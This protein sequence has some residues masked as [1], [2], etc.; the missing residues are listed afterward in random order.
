M[1]RPTLAF[2]V[3]TYALAVPFWVLGGT[4]DLQLL[5][6][7][8]VAGLMFVCPGVAALV[9]SHRRGGMQS[10]KALVRKA[11]DYR[12]V[13]ANLLY[14]PI[15]LL[16]P[17]ILVLSYVAQRA[18]DAPVPAPAIEVSSAL[19]LFALFLVPAA[20]EE[21]GWTGYALR[22]LQVRRH[23]LTAALIVGVAWAAWH[24]VALQQVHRSVEW[25][26]W[27][28]LW[29]VSARVIMVWIYNRSGGS[30]FATV[31]YHTVS[32]AAW[33]SYPV[34]GSFFDPRVTGLITTVVALAAGISLLAMEP[35]RTH[36][37]D[38]VS[39]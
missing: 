6:G 17:G 11:F 37:D 16:T 7:L 12:S 24:W 8:P 27:W 14:L 38:R 2:F 39:Q 33:Q 23:A 28:T 19:G 22:Q 20:F 18:L 34:H 1:T 32:N 15:L 36:R 30:V 4:V 26:A 35:P 3:L 31:L 25:I 9:L 29:S 5:P 21:I 13:R 10:V